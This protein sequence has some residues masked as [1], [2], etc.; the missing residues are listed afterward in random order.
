VGARGLYDNSGLMLAL[1]VEDALEAE[2]IVADNREFIDAVKLGSTILVSHRGGMGLIS[3]IYDDY[4]I[5][6]L[7]DAK[8]KDVPHVLLS[9]IRSYRAHGAAAV[10]CWA[11]IGGEAIR[12]LIENSPKGIDIVVLTALTSLHLEEIELSAKDSVLKATEAGC[13][14]IQVPGNYPELISW[15]R[16]RTLP[17]VKIIS[18]GIGRQGGQIGEAIRCGADYEIIGRHILDRVD[19]RSAFRDCAG[20]IRQRLVERRGRVT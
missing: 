2:A 10:T 13:R 17:E 9:T 18:C 4:G 5:P 6:V 1:D 19:V 15:T 16:Q 14:F 12:F 7:I 20:I 3:K 11:D 8:L